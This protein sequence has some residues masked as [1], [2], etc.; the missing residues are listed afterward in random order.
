MAH[1]EELR[2]KHEAA[3][4]EADRLYQELQEATRLQALESLKNVDVDFY[5]KRL[6]RIKTYVD[7]YDTKYTFRKQEHPYQDDFHEVMRDPLDWKIAEYDL[8]GMQVY[9]EI[10]FDYH[11]DGV[12]EFVKTWMSEHIPDATYRENDREMFGFRQ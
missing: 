4:E 8:L 3:Q 5:T 9:V 6:E 1:I 2:A 11:C 12:K 10:V 7:G